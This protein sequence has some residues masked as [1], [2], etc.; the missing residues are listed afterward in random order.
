MS[1]RRRPTRAPD[2]RRA[3][4]LDAALV[5]FAE[6]GFAGASTNAIADRAKVAKGLLFHHFGSKEELFYAV[7]DDVIANLV[8]AFEKVLDDAPRDL[9][10]RVLAWTEVKLTLM[11]EDPR[12]LRFFLVALTDAPEEVRDEAKVRMERSMRALLPRFMDGIDDDRLRAGVSRAEALEAIFLL[13][14]GFERMIVPLLSLKRG[15]ALEVVGHTLVKAKR[16]LELLR[17]GLYRPRDDEGG[18]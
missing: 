4:I 10:A 1:T 2:A 12:R 9:F 18:E 15:D 17:D 14:S 13:S 16:M 5:E 8:P 3:Q 7:A 11:K 6:K